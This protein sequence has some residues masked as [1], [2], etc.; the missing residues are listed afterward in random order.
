MFGY[1][2]PFKPEM[3]IKEF[4]TYK[5]I[6]CGLCK[7]LGKEYGPFSRFT[8]S[9]DYTFLSLLSLG[10][11]DECAGFKKERCPVHPIQKKPCLC[12]CDDLTFTASAAMLMVYYKLKDNYEDGSFWDK[13][14]TLPLLPF[15]KRKARKAEGRYPKLGETMKHYIDAQKQIEAAEGYSVDRAGEPTAQALGSI[16]EMLVPEGSDTRVLSRLGYLVGRYVYF[17]DA[18][19]DL[20]DDAKTGNFNVFY[21]KAKAEN[22]SLDDVR[23]YAKGVLNLTIGQIGEAYELL[24]L[25]RYK[26]ILDNIVYLGFHDSL[27]RVLQREPIQKREA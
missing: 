9:Y 22:L 8:L 15:F 5:A 20:D 6:Y 10:L 23:D 26:P 24:S 16:C 1:I 11:R 18:L 13:C 4:D 17:I 25:K 27:G 7:Q 21:R 19:D 3:K 14:K 12:A 2:K